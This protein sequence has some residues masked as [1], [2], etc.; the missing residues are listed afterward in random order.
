[1]AQPAG[2]GVGVLVHPTETPGGLQVESQELVVQYLYDHHKHG[3]YIGTHQ[4]FRHGVSCLIITI[5]Q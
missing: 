2:R 3:S 5:V 1:M 4:F